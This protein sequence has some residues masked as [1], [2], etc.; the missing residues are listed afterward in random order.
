M[1][2]LNPWVLCFITAITALMTLQQWRWRG[3][4]SSRSWRLPAILCL[5]GTVILVREASSALPQ[6]GELLLL[7]AEAVVGAGIG[8]AIGAVADIRRP[9]AKRRR[10]FGRDLPVDYDTRNGMTGMALWVGFIVAR[11]ALGL[12]A[13]TWDSHLIRS[14]GVA[15]IALGICRLARSI[16]IS[17][18]A[19]V[20]SA[21]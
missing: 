6:T 5:I 2:P 21:V 20:I 8:I 18:R 12:W 10:R 7:L 16:T 15:L 19:R 4:S 17:R 13:Q 14:A 1:D 9:G 3:T 11:I